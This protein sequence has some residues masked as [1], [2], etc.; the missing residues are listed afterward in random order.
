LVYLLVTV[1][2]LKTRLQRNETDLGVLRLRVAELASPATTPASTAVAGVQGDLPDVAE[3]AG[4]AKGTLYLYYSDKEALFEGVLRGSIGE[5]MTALAASSRN[6]HET[7]RAFVGRTIL[8]FLRDMESSQRAAVVRLMISEGGR[9]PA[10]ASMYRQVVLEPAMNW[11]R[12]LA[13]EAVAR[14]ELKSEA[15]VRFPLLLLSPGLM[16]MVWN[17]MYG[18]EQPINAADAFEAFLDLTFPKRVRG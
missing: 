4:L 8:P 3:R 17:G 18:A 11:I 16:A 10:L 12:Q 14:G 9:F 6:V 5:P 13:A 7:T 1:G 2:G 15:L